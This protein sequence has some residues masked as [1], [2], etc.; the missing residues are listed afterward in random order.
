MYLSVVKIWWHLAIWFR[1]YICSK[2]GLSYDCSLYCTD[3]VLY[4]VSFDLVNFGIMLW[5]LWMNC[6]EF[7]KLSRMS[8]CKSFGFVELL[9]WFNYRTALLH[10]KPNVSVK[11]IFVIF[12]HVCD[13]TRCLNWLRWVWVQMLGL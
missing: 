7:H 12:K 8:S 10:V 11:C 3:Q 4:L 5:C 13:V 1:S 2:F 6:R 9:L